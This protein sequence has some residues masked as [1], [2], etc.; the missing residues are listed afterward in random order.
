[1]TS[2][3]RNDMT[4]S[5]VTSSVGYTN[6]IPTLLF[7][8]FYVV[9]LLAVRRFLIVKPLRRSLKSQIK[10][11][12]ADWPGTLEAPE[13]KGLL[14]DAEKLIERPGTSSLLFW[15]QGEEIAAWSLVHRV[16]RAIYS[17]LPLDDARAA[18][19]ALSRS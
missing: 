4:P 15:S 8:V 10:Q 11:V 13:I 3:A 5:T 19:K 12:R 7:I 16:E 18:C 9:L 17:S 2:I 14:C 1:M 6:L